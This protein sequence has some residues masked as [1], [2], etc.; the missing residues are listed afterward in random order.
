MSSDSARAR[1][2]SWAWRSGW[3]DLWAVGAGGDVARPE[4]CHG[5]RD[6]P[7]RRLAQHRSPDRLLP[8]R[9]ATD[10]ERL[11]CPGTLPSPTR[12]INAEVKHD[13]SPSLHDHRSGW[14]WTGRSV[15]WAMASRA[16]PGLRRF[17]WAVASCWGISGACRTAGRGSATVS[18]LGGRFWRRRTGSGRSRLPSARCSPAEAAGDR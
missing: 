11:P 4:P 18:R 15:R 7:R 17:L 12:P 3:P 5:G 2:R 10:R 16:V 14:C 9:S 13:R 8:G 1:R 6:D